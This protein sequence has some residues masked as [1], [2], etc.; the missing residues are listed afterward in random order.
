MI[1][2]QCGKVKREG[3]HAFF[4]E[5]RRRKVYRAA[6]AYAIVG[7]VIIQVVATVFPYS[8]CR[9]GLCEPL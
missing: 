2:A 9:H 3:I 4:Y 8:H 7:W 5:L 6:A 1:A